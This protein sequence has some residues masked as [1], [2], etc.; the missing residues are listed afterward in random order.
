MHDLR[1]MIQTPILLIA[2]NRPVFTR[3]L[4][5]YLEQ[6]NISK[7]YIYVDYASENSNLELNLQVRKIVNDF[8]PKFEVIKVLRDKNLGGKV[9]VFKAISEVFNLEEKLII[10]EDDLWP[11]RDFFY[12][13]EEMLEKYKDNSRVMSISGNS[14]FNLGSNILLSKYP[15]VWGW[16]TW[17]RAWNLYDLDLADWTPESPPKWF[18]DYPFRSLLIKEYWKSN[19]DSMFYQ[20]IDTWD[21]QLSYCSLRFNLVNIHPPVNLVMNRGFSRSATHTKSR[22]SKPTFNNSQLE[23]SQ[24]EPPSLEKGLIYDAEWENHLALIRY[25]KFSYVARKLSLRIKEN[26]NRF[27]SR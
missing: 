2:Y 10:L 26:F 9:G 5:L 18:E 23:L 8:K 1:Y 24:Y 22:I 21:F 14:F 16:A 17:K 4:L 11:D 20:E 6:F 3:N 7:L 13:C 25:R 27:L 15:H 19:F 12:F